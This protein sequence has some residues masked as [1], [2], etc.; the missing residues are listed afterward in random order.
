MG[1]TYRSCT[2]HMVTVVWTSQTGWQTPALR[3]YGPLSLMP[4]ASCLHYAT[5]CFEGL[6]LYRGHDARLRLF[7]PDLNAARMLHSA[8][9][10]ALPAFSPAQLL[11]LIVTLCALDGPR[12]L[13]RARPGTFLYLRPTMIA[14]APALGVQKPSEATLFIIANCF[15]D[16]KAS[17]QARPVPGMRLLAS[18]D[19][20]C[21]AWPGG[22][23]HAKVGANY[24]P[25]LVAQAEAR[26]RGYDQIL[27]L[28]GRNAL[29]TEAGASNFFVVWM[30]E[31]GVRQLVTASLGE[32]IILPGITRRSVLELAHERFVGE[33]QVVERMFEM[34]E[35]ASAA[36]EGR[37]LE[38]F[39]TGTAVCC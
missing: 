14:S 35:L 30:N 15:P 8:T 21:R 12:W 38:A 32:G 34:E 29:V 1:L 13:P 27:W 2:D 23:G 16:L 4:T 19:D 17:L 7:R 28:F 25:S 24:G 18:E 22:L 5:E 36:A 20:A 10:I 6:K 33:L 26:A 39:A 3:P 9:R 31:K 11:A 37:L